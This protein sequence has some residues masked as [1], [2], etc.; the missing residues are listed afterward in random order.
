VSTLPA[1]IRSL[2]LDEQARLDNQFIEGVDLESYLR[3]LGDTAEI[4][5]DC[6]AGRCRALV[7]FYCNDTTTRQAYITLVLVDPGHRGAGLGRA[8]VGGV[9]DIARRRGFTSCRLEVAKRNDAARAM[10]DAIGFRVVED[11]VVKDLLEI[12]L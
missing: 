1:S 4:L 7:A 9:L 2:I 3:K 12:A 10:Y 11:R 5:S 6:V 8:L